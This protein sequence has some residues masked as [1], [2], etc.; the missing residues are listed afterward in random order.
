MQ[1]DM[2]RF[3]AY[4]TTIRKFSDRTS[5]D[6][7]HYTKRLLSKYSPDEIWV[8]DTDDLVIKLLGYKPSLRYMVSNWR[9][10]IN[11]YRDYIGYIKHTKTV[12]CPKLECET[13]PESDESKYHRN[14]NV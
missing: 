13:C 1:Y 14:R 9:Y 2:Q 3:Y 5:R 11:R 8:G 6:I 4:L 7:V 12:Y 10:S